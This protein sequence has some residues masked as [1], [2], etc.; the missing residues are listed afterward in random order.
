MVNMGWGFHVEVDDGHLHLFPSGVSRWCG[1]GP[2]SV[3]WERVE[4]IGPA[5]FRRARVRI[6]ATTL[7]GPAWCL[8]LAERQDDAGERST[9]RS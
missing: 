4:W 5:P 2:A 1:L 6:G 9:T 7:R 3:P 8:S